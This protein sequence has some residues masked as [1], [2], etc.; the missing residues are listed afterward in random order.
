MYL[1]HFFHEYFCIPNIV[2]HIYQKF[3]FFYKYSES[4]W[5][6]SF[7]LNFPDFI[8]LSLLDK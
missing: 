5:K 6:Y 2:N 3:I 7:I 8:L 1:Y 4:S